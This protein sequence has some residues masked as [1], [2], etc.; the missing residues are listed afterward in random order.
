MG[1]KARICC[2]VKH[3]VIVKLNFV[4]DSNFMG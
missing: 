2:Q 4:T 1:H 3:E